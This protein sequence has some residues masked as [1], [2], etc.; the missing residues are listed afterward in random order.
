MLNNDLEEGVVPES[1]K[2][3][4]RCA[5]PEHSDRVIE[6]YQCKGMVK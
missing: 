1:V 4:D 6:S 5:V 3:I 2:V